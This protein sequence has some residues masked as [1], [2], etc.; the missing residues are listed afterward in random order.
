MRWHELELAEQ[1]LG[2]EGWNYV[3]AAL[4]RNATPRHTNP[5]FPGLRVFT[6]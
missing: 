4:M 5:G 3:F 6:D 1:E 2:F